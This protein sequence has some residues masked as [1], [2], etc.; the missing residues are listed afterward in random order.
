MFNAYTFR[1]EINRLINMSNLTV[2]KKSVQLLFRSL[3]LEVIDVY[4]QCRVIS[5]L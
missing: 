1:E 3:T 4:I 2:H 5:N